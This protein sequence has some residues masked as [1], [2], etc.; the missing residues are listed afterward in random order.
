[1]RAHHCFI[2]RN[3]NRV[4]Q[5]RDRSLSCPQ[6]PIT[7][8]QTDTTT[9]QSATFLNHLNALR[10]PRNM[11]TRRLAQAE[12]NPELNKTAK[13]ASIW[14][15]LW[16][17]VVSAK[18]EKNGLLSKEFMNLP[19][20]RKLADYYQ[21]I[22]DPIDLVSIEQNIGTGCY[23]TAESF[24]GDMLRVFSNAVKFFGRTSET[25]IAATRLKK[26]YR[27]AKVACLEKLQDVLGQKLPPS[28]TCSKKKGGGSYQNFKQISTA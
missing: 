2:V 8:A 11:K 9:D 25:G 17:A 13:L 15:D 5:V 6:Q 4:K 1:M 12:D 24:D 19:S 16:N 7:R 21:R 28:F 22:T 18:D 10:K 3:L 14:R 20:K 26:V 23:R 27:E